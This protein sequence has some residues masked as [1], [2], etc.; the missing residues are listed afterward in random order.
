MQDNTRGTIPSLLRSDSNEC[1]PLLHTQCTAMESGAGEN[2]MPKSII[3]GDF[4]RGA[5]NDA[6]FVNKPEEAFVKY[7]RLLQPQRGE[8][9]ALN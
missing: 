5:T 4:P 6:L 8:L 2:H 1:I 9:E 7:L 3:L